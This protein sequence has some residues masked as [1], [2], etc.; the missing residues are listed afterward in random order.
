MELRLP[1]AI[2]ARM[3]SYSP[4]GLLLLRHDFLPNESLGEVPESLEFKSLLRLGGGGGGGGGSGSL[5]RLG[6]GGGGGGGG[7]GALSRRHSPERRPVH[8]GGSRTRGGLAREDANAH[9]INIGHGR[10]NVQ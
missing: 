9:N 5:L 7:K 8:R 6:G 1:L 10:C 4:C 3:A 2:T